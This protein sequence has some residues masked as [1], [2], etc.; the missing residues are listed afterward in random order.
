MK[1]L[2]LITTGLLLITWGT[3]SCAG[4]NSEKEREDSIRIDDP[5]ANI[6]E[7]QAEDQAMAAQA[8]LDSIRQDSIANEENLRIKPQYLSYDTDFQKKIKSL[9][10]KKVKEKVEETEDGI[11][12]GEVRYERVLNG[13]KI[14]YEKSW[15]TCTVEILTFQDPS[16][17]KRFKEDM[18]NFGYKKEGENYVSKKQS[19]YP[20]LSIEGNKIFFGGC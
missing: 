16:D 4:T 12:E 15:D 13:R 1:K 6:E 10:F 18:L 20:E 14:I 17:L 19:N 8:R 5:V 3:I 11:E 2:I 7:N 9:G